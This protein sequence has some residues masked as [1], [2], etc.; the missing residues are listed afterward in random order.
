MLNSHFK[1]YIMILGRKCIK[2]FRAYNEDIERQGACVDEWGNDMI[3][4]FVKFLIL[5]IK[6]QQLKFVEV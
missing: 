5:A 6:I 2:T 1:K 3:C 4:T